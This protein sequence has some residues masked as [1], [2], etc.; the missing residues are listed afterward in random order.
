M[1]HIVL[2]QPEIP[3]NTGN[4]IRLCANTG[5]NLHLIHP[6][7]FELNDKKLR[8]AGLDYK[9]FA[10]IR[11]YQS[12]Q[13]FIQEIDPGR[14]FAVSTKGTQGYSD[15]A[16]D[17]NDAF[18]FGP[19][20]RGLPADILSEFSSSEILRIPMLAESRSLNLSNAAAV[21]VYEA[22]KQLGFPS[23][24]IHGSKVNH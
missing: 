12:L 17:L 14:I 7:G 18:L 3:P 2:Y 9:E 23:G 8:R 19:E 13:E 6:L 11:E 1:F 4:I 22:W 5:T 20:T 24:Q 16:F 21:L 10:E 15:V